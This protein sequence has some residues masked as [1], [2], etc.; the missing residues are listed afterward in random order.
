MRFSM[1][2][3]GHQPPGNFDFV[4]QQGLDV[5]YAPVLDLIEE[6]PWLR[7]SLHYSGSLLEWLEEHAPDRVDQIARL[8]QAGQVELVAAGMYEPILALLPK[9]DRV[10][11]IRAH[12]AYLQRLFGV[13]THLGWLT[14]RVWQTELAADL[15]E[16]GIE[17]IPLDGRHFRAAGLDADQLGVPYVTEAQGRPLLVAPA[18]EDVRMAIPW[19]PVED[20]LDL[21]RRKARDGTPLSVY[22][23]DIEKWGMW[24]GTHQTVIRGRWLARFFDGLRDLEGVEVVPF[25]EAMAAVPPA[26]PLYIP[27]GSYMEMQEW[28]LPPRAQR[29]FHEA[30]EAL[31]RGQLLEQVE[32]FLHGGQYL[33]FMAKYPEVNHLQKRMLDLSNRAEE[34]ASHRG[35]PRPDAGG[36]DEV[37]AWRREL[38]RAQANCA[39]WHGLFGG[40]YLPHIRQRLWRH[41][42]RA[43]AALDADGAKRQA[44]RVFDLDADRQD[45]VMVTTPAL[46]AVVD[47]QEGALVELS[48]RAAEVNLVDTVARREEAYHEPDEPPY[49]YDRGRRALFVDRFLAPGRPPKV[50]DHVTDLGDFEGKPYAATA[51]EARSGV[52]VTL[53]RTGDAP[54]G[55][56]R[57]EK[58]LRFPM[59]TPDVEARYRVTAAH[60]TL[61]ARFG[62]ELSLG[63]L[64]GERPRGTVEAGGRSVAVPRGGAARAVD[65]ATVTMEDIDVV[66][67]IRVSPAAD[68]DVRPIETVSRAE[69]TFDRTPQELALLFTWPVRLEGDAA[70]EPTVTLSLGADVEGGP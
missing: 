30:R 6:R 64:F 66:L 7:V 14:E 29:A 28:S 56:A 39:Y 15:V 34:H 5:C 33:E 25:G 9:R 16:G 37:P 55:Q 12:R 48:D 68:L 50:R 10:D 45:E 2:L 26:G 47:P 61:D 62:V 46:I 35:D 23:D 57:V 65:A 67:R 3:H 18:G 20:A 41:L 49:P 13:D 63:V 52:E 53:D 19:K 51:R 42:I 54:G 36:G 8:V 1:L 59:Q 43:E 4:F 58:T 22:A 40:V 69:D 31:G 21:L 27:E 17:A 60:G 44:L 32:P 38:W 70:F 24:P 11:Q